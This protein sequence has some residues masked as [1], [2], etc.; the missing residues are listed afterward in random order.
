MAVEAELDAAGRLNT[1]KGSIV[2]AAAE[3][4]SRSDFDNGSGFAALLRE[5]RFCLDAALDGAKV[6]FDALDELRV[7]REAK[8]G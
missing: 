7:R 5:L 8:R 4:L 6:P 3:R 1:A 2:V